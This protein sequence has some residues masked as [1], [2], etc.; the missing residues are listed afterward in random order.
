MSDVFR[1]LSRPLL[2]V[3][4][5]ELVRWVTEHPVE[6]WPT[7]YDVRSMVVQGFE[8]EVAPV[9]AAVLS[10][11]EPGCTTEGLHLSG[12]AAGDVI[13]L[14]TDTDIGHHLARIHVPI[15]TN[16]EARIYQGEERV[17]IHMKA[18]VAYLFDKTLIHAIHNDGP[19]VRLHLI[20]DVA[21]PA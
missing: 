5:S 3:D 1:G 10:H 13:P 15:L 17:P 11:F 14:H 16:P 6:Q 2:T 4:V 20:F 12:I 7:K 8:R 21:R 18:G 9:V 19:T